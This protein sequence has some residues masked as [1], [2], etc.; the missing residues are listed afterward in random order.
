MVF[1]RWAALISLP[2][3]AAAHAHGERT[4]VRVQL[5]PVNVPGLIVQVHQTVLAPQLVVANNTAQVF[6]VL[7]AEG[8]T[9]VRIAPRAAQGWFDPRLSTAALNVPVAYLAQSRELPL[10]EWRIPA[11]LGDQELELRGVFVYAPP[12][13]GVIKTLLLSSAQPFSGIEIAVT[14]GTLP[15][16]FLKNT[17]KEEVEVLDAQSRAFLKIT[18]QGV[19]ADVSSAAWQASATRQVAPGSKGWIKLSSAS[20][21]VWLEPR[22]AYTAFIERDRASGRLNQWSVPL[23]SAGKRLDLRG[24]NN[25]VVRPRKSN[26]Q[27]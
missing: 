23:R 27:S 17:S 24:A 21:F 25:W 7:D 5:E 12:P 16:I 2:V 4:D 9:L 13:Q 8:R 20:S 15:A 22:A 14:S 6:E 11:R 19:W 1:M 3:V 18:P 10:G 26:K